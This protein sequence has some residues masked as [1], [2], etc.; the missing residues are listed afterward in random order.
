MK[1]GNYRYGRSNPD[2]LQLRKEQLVSTSYTNGYGTVDWVR[3]EHPG[4][5]AGV[6]TELFPVAEPVERV[7]ERGTVN[8]QSGATKSGGQKHESQ[9][10]LRPL[11]RKILCSTRN[12]RVKAGIATACMQPEGSFAFKK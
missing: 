4:S 11:Q 10:P 8:S 3:M 2:A 1:T 7:V 9:V 5:L 6:P 12:G